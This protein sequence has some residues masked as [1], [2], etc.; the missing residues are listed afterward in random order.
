MVRRDYFAHDSLG[1]GELRG[2]H[3]PRAATC[4]GRAA[5]PS[6]RTSP[7]APRRSPPRAIMRAWMNS[8][9]H[10]ANILN[11]SL[12]RGRDRRRVGAPVR[13]AAGRGHLH[14]RLRRRAASR[15]SSPPPEASLS[16]SHPRAREPDRR[17]WL[18]QPSRSASALDPLWR[19][20]DDSAARGQVHRPDPHVHAEDPG[21][22]GLRPVGRSRPSRQP[23]ARGQAVHLRD[24]RLRSHHVPALDRPARDP[25]RP[26]RTLGSRYRSHRRAAT[27]LRG[28]AAGGDLDRR[29][30]QARLQLPP[31]GRRHPALRAPPRRA[32]R[33]AAWSSCAPT[34]RRPGP[35]RSSPR[36]TE[37]PGVSL[38]A[39]Q[40]L[41]PRAAH[42]V[43]RPRAARH[44]LHAHARG[45]VLADAQRLRAS[46]GRGRPRPACRTPAASWRSASRASAGASGG[47]A[48][49]IA[50]CPPGTKRGV[51]IGEVP[52][53][54]LQK[55]DTPLHWDPTRS[56]MLAAW[57]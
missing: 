45:R 51:R 23:G 38:D 18:P 25:A 5:G 48:R 46:R 4:A 57:A 8:P 10:R 9:G 6:A 3:P 37:F 39:L 40:V 15:R 7:G 30:G 55:Y 52:E 1:G 14:D 11:G 36:C 16:G 34:G 27:D 2:P 44:G 19:V 42:P 32:S 12:P 50:I 47:F 49:F 33:A 13:A 29:A 31:P 41:P 26:A 21:L 17:R 56:S 53:A 22:V 24:R 54:P 43:P 20:Y 28:A 35:T